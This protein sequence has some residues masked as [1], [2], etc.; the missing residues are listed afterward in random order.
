MGAPARS[1]RGFTY[2][3]VLFLVVMTS[4]G[5][6]ALGRAWSQQAERERERELQFR[7]EAIARAITRYQQA[8]PNQAADLPRSLDDLLEDRRGPVTLRHLRQR[9]ADPFTGQADWELVSQ[10]P[11]LTRFSAVRSRSDHALLREWTPQAQAISKASDW[12]FVAPPPDA[13]AQ[14]ASAPV[15]ASTPRR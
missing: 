3:F 15:A 7:G 9:Y 4:A 8:S 6:A 5:L 14:A 1:Q 11:D 2:L 13:A 12:L 10:S